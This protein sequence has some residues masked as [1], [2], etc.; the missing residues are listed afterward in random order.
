MIKIKIKMIKSG[1]MYCTYT[2]YMHI[3]A[4]HN[5]CIYTHYIIHAYI[6]TT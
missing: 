2:H 1:Y 6:R 3:Y 5:T 4:L